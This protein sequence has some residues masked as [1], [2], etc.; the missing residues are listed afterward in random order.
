[1]RA[2][3]LG[4]R[5]VTLLLIILLGVSGS[6]QDGL[7]LQQATVERV[8][9]WDELLSAYD[10]YIECPSQNRARSLI[11]ALPQDAPTERSGDAEATL[12]HIFSIDYHPV[13]REEAESGVAEAAEI[14]FRLLNITDG[15]YA[16]NVKSMLGFILRNHPRMF[17]GLLNKYKSIKRIKMWGYPIDFIGAGHNM[18][19]KAALHILKKRIEALETVQDGDLIDS[20]GCMHWPIAKDNRTLFAERY[21]LEKG[22]PSLFVG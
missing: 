8:F 18:H 20:S 13:L 11:K 9:H 19:L 16:E 22:P 3:L 15:L 4:L 14:Y 7:A 21:T 2:N 17:L 10:A 5:K 1:M 6:S 12:F